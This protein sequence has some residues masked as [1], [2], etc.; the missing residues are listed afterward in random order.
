MRRR[1]AVSYAGCA[2]V[3]AVSYTAIAFLVATIPELLDFTRRARVI[4]NGKLVWRLVSG[5][6][7]EELARLQK[8][9]GIPPKNA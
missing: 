2:Q 1:L 9:A 5:L 7:P 3:R 6:K 4:R 8:S